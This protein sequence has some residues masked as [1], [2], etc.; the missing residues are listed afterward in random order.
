VPVLDTCR[1]DPIPVSA[2]YLEGRRLP[3]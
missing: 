2:V 1:G 3:R